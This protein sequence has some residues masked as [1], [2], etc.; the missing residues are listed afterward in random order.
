MTSTT[1]KATT[2]LLTFLLSTSTVYPTPAET[3]YQ[4]WLR[5]AEAARKRGDYDTAL[6]NYQR[7][8]DASP[9]GP[10]DNDINTAI[11]EVLEQRLQRLERI[12]PNYGRYVR[13]ADRAYS[14]GE[15][16]TA[17]ANYRR[18]LNE[19]P[20]DRYATVRIQQSQCIKKYRPATGAQ[21][22]TFGCPTL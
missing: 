22:R 6:T 13:V 8:A 1:F 15:Y 11:G 9:N 7:A 4:R 20:G 16:D 12:A 19:R 10:N 17:I 21:F 14:N 3:D 5:M 2:L 18:A